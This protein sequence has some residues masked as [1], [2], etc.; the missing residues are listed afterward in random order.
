MSLKASL[1]LADQGCFYVGGRYTTVPDGDIMTGQMFVQFQVPENQV[2][3]YPLVMI[4]GGG[5]TAT[6]FLVTPDDRP[7]WADFF[8]SHGYAVY[9]VD[10]PARARSGLFSEVYGPTRRR[11]RLQ[12]E[13]HL[14]A[15]AKHNLW[16]RAHLHTQWPG[17]GVAGD[18]IFDQFFA[19]QVEFIS[20]DE[21]TQELFRDAGSALLDRI[22]P[23]ILVAHSQGATCGWLAADA[24]PEHVKAI[25]AVEPWGPPFENYNRSTGP[26]WGITDVPITY[27]PPVTHPSELSR[28]RRDPHSASQL[29]CCWQQTQPAREL[30]RLKHV[31]ILIVTGEASYHAHYDHCTSEFLRQAGVE[32]THLMLEEV[33]I[34]GNGHMLMLEKNNWEIAQAIHNWVEGV[35]E[36]G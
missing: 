30:P 34:R 4:H 23:S 10:Q 17:T 12:A 32:N 15:P 5:Q 29:I 36:R 16:P 21:L 22:G 19:S 7:G 1:A 6:N 33:G 18:P 28:V 3:P 25:V 20:N 27:E 8:V 26:V 9:L 13:Q 11:T 24:R 35:T 14:T 31:P 2:H